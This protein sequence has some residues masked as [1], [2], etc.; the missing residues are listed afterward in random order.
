[1]KIIKKYGLTMALTVA[2]I[3]SFVLS[4]VLWIN[5]SYEHVRKG[6]ENEAKNNLVSKPLSYTYDPTQAIQTSDDH[7][8]WILTNSSVNIISEIV[9]HMHYKHVSQLKEVSHGSAERYL[10]YLNR[11]RSLVLSYQDDVTIPILNSVVKGGLSR[12]PERRLNRIVVPL[13]SAHYFYLLCDHD[14]R[15]Y[16]VSAFLKSFK[17]LRRTVD[18]NGR[19]IRVRIK[20]HQNQPFVSYPK[21]I[22]MPQYDYLVNRQSQNYYVTHLL[23]GVQRISRTAHKGRTVYSNGSDRRLMFGKYRDVKYINDRSVKKPRG[24]NRTLFA[25]YRS[26]LPLNLSLNGVHY[27]GYSPRHHSVLYRRFVEG[28]PIFNPTQFGILK[29]THENGNLIFNYSLNELQIPIPNNR[30]PVRLPN[31]EKVLSTLKA[32]GYDSK[33]V[34]ALEIGY[35]WQSAKTSK[36]LANL[37]PEWFVKYHHHWLNY[38]QIKAEV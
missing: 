15:V 13:N 25:S 6:R 38:D 10:R 20:L 12:L 5:P 29:I 16:K 23:N 21:S 32:H 1:M 24:L 4:V 28:F 26:V 35:E 34:Q 8:Q 9:N 11:P 31:S 27:F 2:V 33:K 14:H 7:K 37:V 19:Q 18:D 30:K 3:I 17:K 36:M 22:Q